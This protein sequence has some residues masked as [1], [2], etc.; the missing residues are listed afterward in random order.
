MAGD[1]ISDWAWI[2]WLLLVLIFLIIEVNTLQLTFL[3]LA[4]GAI[5]ALVAELLGAVWWVQI[6]TAAVLSLL[7]LFVARPPLLR[8][9][10]RGG[11]PTRSNVDALRG[12]EGSVT[13]GV[14]RRART[15]APRQRRDLDGPGRC[16]LR[17]SGAG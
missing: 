11:D 13:A 4:I 6:I 16:R 15:G 10:K 17:R 9:L 5:G 3:M 2:F 14:P 8:I 1:V 12:L 7:L